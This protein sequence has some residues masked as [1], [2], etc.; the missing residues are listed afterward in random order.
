MNPYEVTVHVQ[1]KKKKKKKK[2]ENVK[3]E[4]VP[5]DSVESKWSQRV[6]EENA[7]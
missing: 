6:E 3:L 5:Q 2:K 7:R 1:E 4:N